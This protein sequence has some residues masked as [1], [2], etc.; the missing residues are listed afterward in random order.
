MNK[1]LT[2]LNAA[3]DIHSSGTWVSAKDI[4]QNSF[5]DV[6]Y[7][8]EEHDNLVTDKGGQAFWGQGS[9]KGVL[10]RWNGAAFDE[11]GDKLYFFGGGHFAY[12][13]NEVYQFDLQA[14]TWTRLTDPAPLTGPE[15]SPADDY[16]HPAPEE[17]PAARHTYDGFTWNP[18]TQTVWLTHNWTNF[19]QRGRQPNDPTF[20]EFDP[21][22]G[23]WT[24]HDL[25]DLD[26]P[27]GSTFP[28]ASFNPE[29]GQLV[30]DSK[31]ENAVH[32]IQP[33]GTIEA[34]NSVA[35]WDNKHLGNMEYN[36][37]DGKMYFIRK[38]TIYRAEQDADGNLVWEAFVDDLPASFPG[39]K[40][41]Y[42][43]V[44]FDFHEPSGRMVL[45]NGGEEIYTFDPATKEFR[46]FD[47]PPGAAAPAD[48]GR[49]LSKFKYVEEADA[50]AA[51]S[52]SDSDMWFFRL[53]DAEQGKILDPD[54]PRARVIDAE[55]NVTAY[56]LIR[57]AVESA[58][59]G[60]T[61]EI[62]PG[63]YEESATVS[64]NNLTIR[65]EG[66]HIKNAIT[67]GKATFV[68]NGNNTTF[69]GLEI[70]GARVSDDQ[71]SPIRL[72]AEDLTLRDV[73]FHDNQKGLIGGRGTVVIENSRFEN[74]SGQERS[75][76][77]YF[78]DGVEK[79]IV[80][81]S[82]FIGMN[83]G[84]HEIKSRAKETIIE[85]SLIAS[86]DGS[87]SRLIDIAEGGHL[88]VRNSVLESG[89]NSTNPEM[90]GFG[91]EMSK[92]VYEDHSV[93]IEDS[94]IINDTGNSAR[95][96]DLASVVGDTPVTIKGN[97]FVGGDNTTAQYY[98]GGQPAGIPEHPNQFFFNRAEAGLDPYPSLPDSP[99]AAADSGLDT[100]DPKVI[101]NKAPNASNDAF[102]TVVGKPISFS[103][104]E[105]LQ[106][107]S[108]P[109]ENPLDFVGIGQP[110]NGRLERE[111]DQFTYTPDDGFTGTDT[112]AYNVTDGLGGVGRGNIEIDVQNVKDG[113]LVLTGDPDWRDRFDV[114]DSDRPYHI[115]GGGGHDI[116]TG[117]PAG[118]LIVGGPGEDRIRGGSGDDVFVYAGLD[119]GPD[120]LLDGGPGQD[121]IVGSDGDDVMRFKNNSPH[122]IERIDG[123]EGYDVIRGW[124]WPQT[125]DF[126]QTALTGVELIDGHRLTHI[127]GSRGDDTFKAS[128]SDRRSID[129]GGGHNAVV[130]DGA[131]A[132]YNVST[133]ENGGLSVTGRVNNTLSNVDVLRFADGIYADGAFRLDATLPPDGSAEDT[134]EVLGPSSNR[135]ST[136]V[137]AAVALDEYVPA[138]D[139]EELIGFEPAE[140]G[141]IV[142]GDDGAVTYAPD[143]GFA[144]SDRLTYSV[145][146]ADGTERAGAL[147]V[148]VRLPWTGTDSDDRVDFRDRNAPREI[149]PADGHDRVVGT[150][151]SDLIRGGQG[152]NW[153]SAGEGDDIF[154]YAGKDN[155]RAKLVDGGPGYD[156]LAGSH[157]DDIMQFRGEGVRSIDVIEGGDGYDV[158][159]GWKSTESWDFSETEV[160]GIE[161]I[162]AAAGHDSVVGSPG[163]D[164]IRGGP[165]E[166]RLWGG[167]GDD[168]FDYTGTDNGR[169]K[170][171]DGGAGFDVVA[172]SHGDD[173][174][175]FR[176]EGLRS[177]ERIEGGDG[178]DV[179][180]GWK[181]PQNWDFSKTEMTG[182][183]LID[184]YNSTGIVGSTGDD[185]FKASG[186]DGASI[187]GGAGEDTVIFDAPFAEYTIDSGS[188]GALI[189]SGATDVTLNN[190]EV[191]QFSDGVYSED[192]FMAEA[193]AV[194]EIQD[195]QSEE[196]KPLSLVGIVDEEV[197]HVSG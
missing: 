120:P 37:A 79:A 125:W 128:G 34:R 55:G 104:D 115:I 130:Y 145:R 150:P 69:E 193:H 149:D 6:A 31:A 17:G 144:G 64:A 155:G 127:I 86:G 174:M 45:W 110:E 85:D 8:K 94:L 88:T 18:E 2:R 29:T 135:V 122:S 14:L 13:G 41:G 10:E 89:P 167:E 175:Q 97:T 19:T 158:I 151:Y 53:P 57:E 49:V 181:W 162:D 172:G 170:L 50:F 112:V 106:N 72:Q 101:N 132:E 124:D 191:L 154:D 32:I 91:K 99:E 12:G 188:E 177:I 16:A 98:V 114:S 152:E 59:D 87:D 27:N 80:R 93:T 163:P 168:V 171:V 47:T 183:E 38:G 121:T 7:S 23:A 176:G 160:T 62:L 107:D 179:I 187:D 20:W 82:E 111:A 4:G 33:D 3:L 143:P 161:L 83:S 26:V 9:D 103:V 28:I 192:A 92:S 1:G 58:P 22:T 190:V 63:T 46:V 95:W 138:T 166:D 195:Q 90:I 136:V 77:V 100:S 140:H 148:T 109:N 74:N 180:R 5:L 137:D 60:A 44:G 116:I 139:G 123:G 108:D 105:L 131:F 141:S 15:M 134:F 153:L 118:D 117:S 164:L 56:E 189:F 156:V 25:T 159:R 129:G 102:D 113:R 182:I 76:G 66:V 30:V 54:A 11:S 186:S 70:S 184:G 169:D 73:Y 39:G 68:V 126:S 36:P 61:V 52:D 165:G 24:G 119:N 196:V 157:G 67:G 43:Y 84:G 51:I 78:S 71:G 35:L 42:T 48:T 81:N 173:L 133:N 146:E 185:T 75:H 147:T 21:E 197:G 40:G 178:Y 96:L 142:E 65:G 194:P